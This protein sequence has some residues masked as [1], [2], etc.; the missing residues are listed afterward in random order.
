MKDLA[1]R[2]T[3]AQSPFATASGGTT[4]VP[5]QT[6]AA[7][8]ARYAAALSALTPPEAMSGTSG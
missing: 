3:S 6:A 1:R 8:C 5:A 4:P 2:V 7:P